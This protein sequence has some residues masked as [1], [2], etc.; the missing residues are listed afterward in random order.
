M[1]TEKKRDED[2]E[3][4]GIWAGEDEESST[5]QKRNRCKVSGWRER[6]RGTWEREDDGNDH[7]R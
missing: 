2:C 7:Q 6:V 3:T 1:G 4:K 5:E